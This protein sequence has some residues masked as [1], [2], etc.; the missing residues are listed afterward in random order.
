VER[1][2]NYKFFASSCATLPDG[3]SS[4]ILSLIIPSRV[5]GVYL[6]PGNFPYEGL[7]TCSIIL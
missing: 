4:T 3:C 1:L 6:L 7:I 5:P 2:G